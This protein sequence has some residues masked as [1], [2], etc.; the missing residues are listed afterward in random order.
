MEIDFSAA[1]NLLA[2]ELRA[3][4]AVIQGYARML[5]DPRF[6]AESRPRMLA[7]IQEA[8]GRIAVL[9]REAVELSRWLDPARAATPASI[10]I[11][12]LV[13]RAIAE[14]GVESSLAPHISPAD[15]AHVVDTTGATALVAALATVIRAAA[16]E[17]PNTTLTVA[18]R[19]AAEHLAHDVLVGSS[20]L[21]DLV[22]SDTGPNAPGS[23]SVGLGRGGLGLS[24]VLAAVVLDAHH[25]RLW[26]VAKRDRG[27]I[28]VQ[29][30]SKEQ[31][32]P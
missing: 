27:I 18:V 9:G 30:P 10:T 31:R 19:P 26:T 5:G 20:S 25:S 22:A 11:Q 15:G 21:D 23:T 16:R 7:Q 17:A 4:T 24:L 6:D 12:Q 8:A 2:H 29:V 14:S 1:L 28:G 32:K 13:E 3:P